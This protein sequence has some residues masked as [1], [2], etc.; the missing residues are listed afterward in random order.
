M[1]QEQD[2]LQRIRERCIE[3]GDCWIWQG[4]VRSHAPRIW[5]PELREYL[6]VR[7][8]IVD[9]QQRRRPGAAYFGSSCGNPLCV[10]PDHIVQRTP[11]QQQSHKSR[12]A[13]SGASLAIRTRKT[14]ASMQ[15]K[16]GKLTM[17]Q[18]REIRAS[19]ATLRVLSQTYGVSIEVARRVRIGR[20]WKEAANP[21]A[22]LM[23]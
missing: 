11:S 9:Q 15:A 2:D 10:H 22:G 17:E 23:R 12:M 21:F 6:P 14:A 13:S 19:D 8:V 20:S 16:A 4:M 5:S 1:N 18:A 3:D 7:A